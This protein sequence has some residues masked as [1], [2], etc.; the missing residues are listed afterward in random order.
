VG[1]ACAVALGG[2]TGVRWVEGPERE[3]A[4]LRFAGPFAFGL[5]PCSARGE[6]G[7]LGLAFAAR[8]AFGFSVGL[9]LGA[10]FA[11]GALPS[12]FGLALAAAGGRAGARRFGRDLD[13]GSVSDGVEEG[14]AGR[15]A[16][17]A[18]RWSP[19]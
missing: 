7:A 11:A 8:F 18:S 13:F 4:A 14:L 16:L 17:A 15:P 19:T 10:G 6:A 2:R 3:L 9:A 1:G 5:A 12:A